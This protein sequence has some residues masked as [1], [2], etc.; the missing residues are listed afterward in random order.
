MNQLTLRGFDRALD[1]RVRE[2]AR[3]H[4]ISRN[5]AALLLLRR[6]AG[7][8]PAEADPTRRV[9]EALDRFIGTWSAR[10]E[11]AVLEAASVFETVDE[12]MW[13]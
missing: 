8:E 11:Q 4:G 12:E 9:G 7:L 5:R 13:R 6:G 3:R 1:R 10:E 2:L